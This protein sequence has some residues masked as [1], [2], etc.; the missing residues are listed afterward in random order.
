MTIEDGHLWIL[1]VRTAHL[2]DRAFIQYLVDMEAQGEISKAEAVARV[3]PSLMERLGLPV[4]SLEAKELARREGRMLTRGIPA[5]PGVGVGVAI[6]S[7]ES[8]MILIRNNKPF[9]WIREAL[10]PK[11][12]LIMKEAKGIVSILS[13]IGSHGAIIANAQKKP[14]IVS[15][16]NID[17]INEE[18]KYFDRWGSR[19]Y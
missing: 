10:D 12:Y 13:S 8:A 5:S 11:E 15:C 2:S 19:S 18:A 9:I 14:C 17:E 6:V 1:Q 16:D 3:R 7:R 4:F